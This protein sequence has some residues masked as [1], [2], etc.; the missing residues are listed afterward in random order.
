MAGITVTDLDALELVTNI[1]LDTDAKTIKINKDSDL[2]APNTGGTLVGIT[3]Q[4]LYS[5]LKEVWKGT[6]TETLVGGDTKDFMRYDNPMISITGEQFEFI[7]GWKP[8]DDTTRKLIRD[9]GWL[10][11]KKDGTITREYAGIKTLGELASDDQPYYQQDGEEAA[12]K[13]TYK[14]AVNE[15]VLIYAAIDEKVDPNT[16]FS[17]DSEG[18]L[19][20]SAPL[21]E[22]F[23][24][25]D[26]FK[27]FCREEQKVYAASDIG[28]IGVSSLTYKLYAFPITNSTDLKVTHT[29]EQ[30][31]DDTTTYGEIDVVYLGDDDA[32]NI[33]IG[34]T[35]YPFSIIIDGKGKTAEQIY[36]K[37]QYLLRQTGDINTGDVGAGEDKK[38]AVFGNTASDLLKFV[39]DTLVTS[40]GVYIEN[41]NPTDINRIEFTDDGGNKRTFPFVAALTI[42]FDTNLVNDGDAV[43]TLYFTNDATGA[44][45]GNN[46][47]TDG[48]IIVQDASVSKKDIK[49]SIG[50][51]AS[52]TFT[53]DYDG[54]DQRGAGSI[55]TDAPITLVAI[56]LENAQ[57]VVATGTITKSNSNVISAVSAL[58]RNFSNPA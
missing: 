33:T 35:A 25:R 54:N 55:K 50:G 8:A 15:C 1:V 17:F 2:I 32:R 41:Y 36:E 31:E 48:A 18:A 56:G 29:D 16:G 9:A 7:N 26:F 42:N 46:F 45:A 51:E 14:D 39:G 24:K 38:D 4:C 20:E 49:G 30:I 21:T 22:K 3:M 5:F 44:N 53:Y 40:Q 19:V 28:S 27:I 12:V 47:G 43:F 58:E 11:R 10:E 52:I 23:E 57:Y 6:K 37:I 13:T 34:G